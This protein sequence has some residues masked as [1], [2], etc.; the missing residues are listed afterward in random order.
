MVWLFSNFGAQGFLK[1]LDSL[2]CTYLITNSTTSK[3]SFEL[4]RPLFQVPFFL[5][6]H[7]LSSTFIIYDQILDILSGS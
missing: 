1:F 6:V 2:S 7:V 3:A 5:K 4:I